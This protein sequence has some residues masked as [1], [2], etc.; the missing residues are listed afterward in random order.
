MRKLQNVPM[1]WRQ[2][3]VRLQIELR[4]I[5]RALSQGGGDNAPEMR[6]RAERLR[7]NISCLS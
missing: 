2:Y 4:E 1:V 6:A 3:I 7:Q 5:E